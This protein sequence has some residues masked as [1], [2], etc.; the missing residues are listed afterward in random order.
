MIQASDLRALSDEQLNNQHRETVAELQD[1]LQ[2]KHTKQV[3]PD[4]I[5]M[6]RKS[7]ARI[8]T[9]QQEK[10]IKA[11]CEI[12]EKKRHVPKE[13]REKK[14]RALRRGLSSHQKHLKSKNT[15]ILMKKY[16]KRIFSYVKQE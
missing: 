3:E 6:A 4:A 11:M 1:L 5:R 2:Q 15:R 8:K 14:T 10:K 16:P 7:I 9:V 13:L 12:Y